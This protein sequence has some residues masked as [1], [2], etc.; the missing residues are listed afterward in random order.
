MTN[1]NVEALQKI[2]SIADYQFGRGVGARLFLDNV[3]I[4][5]SSSTKRIRYVYDNDNDELL[6]TLRPTDG[7]FSLNIEGAKRLHK[8]INS[9][10]LQVQVSSEVAQF[11]RKGSDVFAKHVTYADKDILPMAVFENHDLYN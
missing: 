10:R 3:K 9:G 7:L 8:I 4:V 1:L 5:F 2:R 11:A 6:V